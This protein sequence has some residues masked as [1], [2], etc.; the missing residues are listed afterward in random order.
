MNIERRV[1]KKAIAEICGVSPRTIDNW[2]RLKG[3]PALKIGSLTRYLISD[4]EAWVAR[5]QANPVEAAKEEEAVA[6]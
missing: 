1:N 3:F 5:H 6:S 4:V 2:V